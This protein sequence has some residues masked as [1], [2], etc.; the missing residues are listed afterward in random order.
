MSWECVHTP[1]IH[2]SFLN[3]SGVAFDSGSN[4]DSCYLLLIS[5]EKWTYSSFRMVK[6]YVNMCLWYLHLATVCRNFLDI[7]ALRNEDK[8][9]S[10]FEDLTPLSSNPKSNKLLRLVFFSEN[11]IHALFQLFK[12]LC[13]IAKYTVLA[14]SYC[15]FY[16]FMDINIC[17]LSR[18][19]WAI[20]WP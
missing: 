20:P 4:N 15:M 6:M 1:K 16:I 10:I 2:C 9:Q 5:W 14:L 17:L 11:P 13:W 7:R 18:W 19:V 12:L 8:C 3:S